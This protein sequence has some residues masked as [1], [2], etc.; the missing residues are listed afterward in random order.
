MERAPRACAEHHCS[1]DELDPRH[2]R[3]KAAAQG[4]RFHRLRLDDAPEELAGSLM[5]DLLRL[6]PQGSIEEALLEEP[7]C[8]DERAGPATR[9]RTAGTGPK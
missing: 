9:S 2:E 5:A 6:K 8:A 3:E 7:P 1:H 4:E